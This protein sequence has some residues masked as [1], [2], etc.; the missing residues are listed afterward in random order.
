MQGRRGESNLHF[1]PVSFLDLIS[2]IMYMLFGMF[3]NT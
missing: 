1:F 3:T 2:I